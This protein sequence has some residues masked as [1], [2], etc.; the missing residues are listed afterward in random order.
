[1]WFS[2]GHF[3]KF[4]LSPTYKVRI[5]NSQ[6]LIIIY[7]EDAGKIL[8]KNIGSIQ[9][10][11]SYLEFLPCITDD[12][13]CSCEEYK[14]YLLVFF[15]QKAFDFSWLFL[16][17]F[18]TYLMT[19]FFVQYFL[20]TIRSRIMYDVFFFLGMPW[21]SN[22]DHLMINVMINVGCSLRFKNYNLVI[23]SWFMKHLQTTG[24]QE[25]IFSFE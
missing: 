13:R 18:S 4:Y 5:T 25:A 8:V 7:K 12:H 21:N 23:V 6:I 9:N 3:L 14:H 17:H 2:D 11:I 16:S 15:L 24:K 22:D 20:Y 19:L 10:F 1:M